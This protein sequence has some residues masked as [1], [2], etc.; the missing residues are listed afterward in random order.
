MDNDLD[1]KEMEERGDKDVGGGGAGNKWEV[2]KKSERVEG[3]GRNG[4]SKEG[5]RER[6]H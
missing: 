5:G 1:G 4:V 6:L 3:T 2:I